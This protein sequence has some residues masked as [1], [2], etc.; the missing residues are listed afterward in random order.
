VKDLMINIDITSF[1]LSL[2]TNGSGISNIGS[3]ITKNYGESITYDFT[4]VVGYEISSVKVNGTEV[5]NSSTLTIDNI[6]QNYNIVVTFIIKTFEISWFNYDGNL[7][8][9]TTV[10]YGVL[11][12]ASFNLPIKPSEGNFIFEFDGWNSKLDGTGT[13]LVEA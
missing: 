13:D 9:T 11:P 1:T 4:P 8:T 3:S 7:I 5:G 12:A 6:D 2:T 10:N